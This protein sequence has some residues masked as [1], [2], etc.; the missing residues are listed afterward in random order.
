MQRIWLQETNLDEKDNGNRSISRTIE[1]EVIEDLVMTFSPGEMVTVTGIVKAFSD[2]ISGVGRSNRDK[3]SLS[4]YIEVSAIQK[5]F[6]KEE[7]TLSNDTHL[8]GKEVEFSEKDLECF[9]EIKSE[10]FKTIV[11]SL[12][13]MIFGNELVKAGLILGL[14]GGTCQVSKLVANYS[15]SLQEKKKNNKINH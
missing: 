13:P 12:C 15:I 7:S 4:L 6:L 9:E 1:C 5:I 10:G 14:F 8:T 3:N 11:N 2:E